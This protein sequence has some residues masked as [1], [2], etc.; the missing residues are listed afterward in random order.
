DK[1]N[2]KEMVSAALLTYPPLMAADILLYNAEIVPVGDDQKQHLELTRDLAERFNKRYREVFTVP[3]ISIPKVGARVMSLQDPTKKMSKSD[4]NTK[5]CLYVLDSPKTIE[6]K[7]KSAV[8]DSEGIVSYDPE[9]KPGIS[10][11]LGI[12]SA[13]T[14]KDIPTLV[15]EYKDANYGTFKQAVADV[16]VAELT[17]I[18]ERYAQLLTSSELDDVLDEGA[19]RATKVARKTLDKVYRAMGV[20]RKR[21]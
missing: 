15:E 3:D 12:L 4:P 18:Q 8:T 21:R 1:S 7:I 19:E 16:V 13:C 6:K 20:G 17:P 2:G 11:L 5:S 10:N 9:N 14:G